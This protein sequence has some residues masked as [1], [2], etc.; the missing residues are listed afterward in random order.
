MEPKPNRSFCSFGFE[1]VLLL[2]LI[3][4]K[5]ATL[6][7]SLKFGLTRYQKEMDGKFG[8]VLNR[9]ISKRVGKL[10]RINQEKYAIQKP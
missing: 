10:R 7:V 9:T 8:N 6:E 1:I 5:R 3:R 2:R 4:R